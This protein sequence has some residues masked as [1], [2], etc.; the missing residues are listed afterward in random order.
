MLESIEKEVKGDLENAF[1]NPV[2]CIQNKPLYFA[3]WL[4]DSRKGK[5]ERDKFQIRTMVSH[6]KVD[7]L[8][9]CLNSKTSMAWPCIPT[10]NNIPRVITRKYC[11]TCT[12]ET[13][14]PPTP[15]PEQPLCFLLTVLEN[16]LA[17]NRP[18]AIP[19]KMMVALPLPP[20]VFQLPKVLSSDFLI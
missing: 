15:H 19:V 12:V 5:G 1:L 17:A 6:R 16:K 10:S 7:M 18:R 2:L 3:N 8:K 14:K 13:L 11:Y 4:Y 9:S 20:A